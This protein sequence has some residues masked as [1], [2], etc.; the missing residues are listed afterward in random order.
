MENQAPAHRQYLAVRFRPGDRRT[1]TYHNDGPPLGAGQE[2]R[3]PDRSGDG[4]TR[5]TVVEAFTAAPT[6]ATKAILGL[7]EA[8][9]DAQEATNLLLSAAGAAG[10]YGSLFDGLDDQ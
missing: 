10:L 7:V 6:F 1:Y 8:D 5:A 9:A 4:W 2:V 3:V